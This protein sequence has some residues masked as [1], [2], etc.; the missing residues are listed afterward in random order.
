MVKQY[1]QLYTWDPLGPDDGYDH[2]SGW[3]CRVSRC[4]KW[5]LRRALRHWR[6]WYA[7]VSILVTRLDYGIPT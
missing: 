2:G 6:G 4:N 1:Y 7:D 5:T 3:N